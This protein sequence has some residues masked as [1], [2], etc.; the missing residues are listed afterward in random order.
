VGFRELF[1]GSPALLNLGEAG[2]M[3]FGEEIELLKC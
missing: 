3:N 1:D 2:M